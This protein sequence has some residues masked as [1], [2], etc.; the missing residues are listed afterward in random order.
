MADGGGDSDG[1]GGG[2][3]VGGGDSVDDGKGDESG[4]ICGL[5]CPAKLKSCAHPH[6]QHRR[7][8]NR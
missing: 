2:R 3:S 7:M 5:N 6:T 4:D 1:Y 8:M